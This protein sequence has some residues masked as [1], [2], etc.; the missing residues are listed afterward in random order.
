MTNSLPNEWTRHGRVVF[1]GWWKAKLQGG[2]AG[3]EYTID[4]VRAMAPCVIMVADEFW[5]YYLAESKL[6]TGGTKTVILKAISSKATPTNF[7][8]TGIAFE[9]PSTVKFSPSVGEDPEGYYAAGPYHTSILPWLDGSG[10]PAIN[11]LTG[12]YYPWYMYMASFGNNPAVAISNDGGGTFNLVSNANPIFPFEIVTVNGVER[13]TPVLSKSK[14]YDYGGTGS[15]FV[16]RHP[17]NKFRMYSTTAG[18]LNLSYDDLGTNASKVGH[19]SGQIADIGIGYSEGSDAVNFERKTYLEL[20]ITS[21]PVRGSGRIIDP[22]REQTPNGLM[23][24]I[25]SKP[26]VFKD[27]FFENGDILWRM[28]V[29]SH[30]TT[31][32]ARSLHSHDLLNWTWDDSPDEGFL[33]LG[34]ANTF[35]SQMTAYPW[36]IRDGDTL[37]CWYTGN[38]YGRRY[39]DILTGIGYATSQ[40]S[41]E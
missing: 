21:E 6:T 16:V 11:P 1:P 2:A 36:L 18:K 13:R 20:N 8:P 26:M 23:E 27:G 35:D 24:Y 29:S 4:G 10:N 9:M 22:R 5:L 41:S 15:S 34:G 17:Y 32:H 38:N 30:T 33:G 12:D 28:T 31:Y 7:I 37:H 3:S 19:A 14:A 40:G 25:V 39:D